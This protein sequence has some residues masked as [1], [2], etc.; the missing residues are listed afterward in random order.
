[1]SAGEDNNKGNEMAEPVTNRNPETLDSIGTALDGIEA[2]LTPSS[3][4]RQSPSGRSVHSTATA[5]MRT[6]GRAVRE[7]IRTALGS[8]RSRLDKV[9]GESTSLTSQSPTDAVNRL[10]QRLRNAEVAHLYRIP[11]NVLQRNLG[12]HPTAPAAEIPGERGEA[13]PKPESISPRRHSLLLASRRLTMAAEGN[14]ADID[15]HARSKCA[16]SVRRRYFRT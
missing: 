10:F 2:H 12:R 14:Q 7:S 3:G 6:L 8:I 15:L 13:F 11:L 5:A 9:E 4:V 1:M 16:C